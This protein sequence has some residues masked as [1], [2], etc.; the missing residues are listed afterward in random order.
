MLKYISIIIPEI[1]Y[2]IS[3]GYDTVLFAKLYHF[4]VA[5]TGLLLSIPLLIGCLVG[6]F[7][8]VV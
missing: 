5:Q 8:A 1:Y 2:L 3:F 7:N 4:N 6:K